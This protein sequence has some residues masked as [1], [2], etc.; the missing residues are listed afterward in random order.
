MAIS[1]AALR[2][3][4]FRFLITARFFSLIAHQILVVT[5]SQYIYE[6][7]RNPLSLGFIGL[8]LF[9]PKMIFT[10][11]AGNVADRFD[12]RN[13]MLFSRLAQTI[14][15]SIIAFYVVS[16]GNSPKIIYALTFL[17]ACSYAFDGPSGQSIIADLVPETDLTNAVTFNAAILQV[18]FILGPAL[19]GALYAL[20]NGAS[21]VLIIVACTR[22]TAAILTLLIRKKGSHHDGQR[23]TWKIAIAGVRYVFENRI[24]L[25]TISLDLFAVLLGG[26]VALMPV[27]ANDILKV[28]PQGF[29]W[30]RAGPFIGAIIT[31]IVFTMLPPLKNSGRSLL[32]CVACFGLFTIFF[33]VSKNFYLSMACLIVMGAVDMV[34][35]VIR[36]V[37][38]QTRT[39]QE[40]RGRVSAVNLIFIGASNELG[41]F[42]S[43]VTAHFFGVVP[44]VIIGGVGTLLVVALWAWLFPEIRK[45]KELH[46]H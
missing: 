44:A 10:L 14:G 42:E 27:F 4:D 41:E 23:L 39:P 33:A 7:T 19:G 21:T 30:L 5:L 46:T 28:G 13:V 11:P 29:G 20:L 32:L 17:L 8:T 43:G 18:A 37:L 3:R 1:I 38:V 2:H 25:G 12:R 35:V 22:L 45:L 24:I 36:G 26:A 16:G 15:V 9:V 6:I 31:S 34:S 40:M